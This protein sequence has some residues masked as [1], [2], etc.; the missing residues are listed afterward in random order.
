MSTICWS[1]QLLRVP[2]TICIR[3]CTWTSTAHVQERWENSRVASFVSRLKIL[4]AGIERQRR[5]NKIKAN[6]CGRFLF[7]NR[8]PYTH[9]E[10]TH[11]SLDENPPIYKR[12][13][14][15]CSEKDAQNLVRCIYSPVH[16]LT[17]CVLD[18][19]FCYVTIAWNFLGRKAVDVALLKLLFSSATLTWEAE[20]EACCSM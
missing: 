8:W 18:G 12:T 1:H 11:E 9:I 4:F 5:S 19:C 17:Q 10:C 2:H 7:E 16:A 13:S 14:D 15:N 20:Q 6:R 3:R